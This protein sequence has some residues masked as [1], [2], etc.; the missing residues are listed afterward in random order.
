MKNSSAG[1]PR[2]EKRV[3]IQFYLY[4]AAVPV[5]L[6]GTRFVQTPEVSAGRAVLHF[7]LFVI[8][9][10]FGFIRTPSQP[11]H[12]ERDAELGAALFFKPP[13]TRRSDSDYRAV[14][15]CHSLSATARPATFVNRT[16]RPMPLHSI[17]QR[18]NRLCAAIRSSCSR[19]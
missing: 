4:L 5:P 8:T 7:V 3:D 16:S 10:Y 19:V 12:P 13:L 15:A 18:P 9:L 11:A 17:S 14:A 1:A 6:L 2:W